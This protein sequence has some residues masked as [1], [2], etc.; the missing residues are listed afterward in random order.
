MNT[1]DRAHSNAPTSRRILAVRIRFKACLHSSAGPR[2]PLTAFLEQKAWALTT[3]ALVAIL[4]IIHRQ[5][6]IYLIL[7]KLRNFF[8]EL[9][10]HQIFA[11]TR[12]C[13]KPGPLLRPVLKH[14]VTFQLPFQLLPPLEF[15]QS[16]EVVLTPMLNLG[17]SR[18][19]G[20]ESPA[21]ASL[22]NFQT[23]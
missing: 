11:F 5:T 2:N 8:A 7:K 17:A 21:F 16:C 19:A 3:K 14:E 6:Y 15:S 13:P 10:F 22:R 1:C 4:K 23:T 12:F 18:K 9:S 20:D